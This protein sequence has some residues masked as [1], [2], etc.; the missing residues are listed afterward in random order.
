MLLLTFQFLNNTIYNIN[1]FIYGIKNGLFNYVLCPDA[2]KPYKIGVI[3]QVSYINMFDIA[4]I[5]GQTD[6][7]HTIQ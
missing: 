3:M 2:G 1:I 6:S 7:M 4:I 5:F